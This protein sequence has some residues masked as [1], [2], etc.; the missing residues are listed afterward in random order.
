MVLLQQTAQ[1]Q[2]M[3]SSTL[4][5]LQGAMW[6]FERTLDEFLQVVKQKLPKK[7]D[8]LP[9]LQ[10]FDVIMTAAMETDFEG[11]DLVCRW[12]ILD[13]VCECGM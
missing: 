1:K 4:R 3:V 7:M 10:Y 13:S 2:T 5:Q 11:E 12:W 8:L 6:R 9:D